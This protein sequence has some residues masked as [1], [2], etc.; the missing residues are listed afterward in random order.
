M[1][2]NTRTAIHNRLIEPEMDDLAPDF[3]RTI[4]RLDQPDR[5]DVSRLTC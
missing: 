3:A 2:A 4:L 5:V 1:T